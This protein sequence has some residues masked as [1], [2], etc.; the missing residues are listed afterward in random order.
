MI[1]LSLLNFNAVRAL[2]KKHYDEQQAA[3]PKEPDHIQ[4]QTLV[5]YRHLNE[6]DFG[7]QNDNVRRLV[8]IIIGEPIPDK[9]AP[10][11]TDNREFVIGTIIVDSS[12]TLLVGAIDRDGD[13]EIVR[14]NGS[15]TN[16]SANGSSYVVK[17]SDWL[18]ASPEEVEA[19]VSAVASHAQETAA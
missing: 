18:Y 12:V 11:A 9:P 16:G 8:S 17:R 19:F 3:F 13:A 5:A 14:A 1:S 10:P 7:C 4:H 6:C 15:P 2:T